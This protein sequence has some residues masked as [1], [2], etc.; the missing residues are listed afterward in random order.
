M[1]IA[2]TVTLVL[3]TLA[4]KF[5]DVSILVRIVMMEMLVPLMAVI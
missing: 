2:M 4:I 5:R 1:L 3:K